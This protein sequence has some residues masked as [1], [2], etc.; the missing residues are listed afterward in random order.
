MR[1][2]TFTAAVIA[3]SLLALFFVWTSPPLPAIYYLYCYVLAQIFFWP[4]AMATQWVARYFRI[5]G[6]PRLSALMGGLSFLMMLCVGGLPFVFLNASYGLRHALVDSVA[7]GAAAAAS[8]I[9][10]GAILGRLSRQRMA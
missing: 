6:V 9:I 10:Y 1:T 7:A 4:A 5:N 2:R 3:P 8:F